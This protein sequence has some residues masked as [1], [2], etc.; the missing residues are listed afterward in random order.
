M[1]WLVAQRVLPVT[2]LPDAA[3]QIKASAL[4]F[5]NWVLAGN[6]VNYLKSDDATSPVQH[7]WSLSVEEQFYLLWPLIFIVAAGVTTLLVRR[8][9]RNRPTHLTIRGIHITGR[10]IALVLAL[11][12]VLISLSYS[13]HETVSNPAGA[14]FQTG[15][16]IWE[17]G[18]GGLLALLP[19][20]VLAR[21]GR[22]GSLSW[23]GLAVIVI[24]AFTFSASTS[25]PGT[26]ALW[27]VLGAAAVLACGSSSARGGSA[28]LMSQRP[29]VALGDLSYGVYLWHFPLIIL[30]QAYHGAGIG[31]LDGP[32]IIAASI[33]LA[34]LTKYLVEDPI[35]KA[36]WLSV[37]TKRSMLVVVLTLIPVTLVTVWQV[38]QPAAKA[39]KIDAAH[40]GAAA[41][42]TSALTSKSASDVVTSKIIP[43]LSKVSTDYELA[44]L[45][46]CKA[47]LTATAAKVCTFG[48][49]TNP[50]L[51]VALVGDSHAAQWSTDLNTIAKQEHWKLV[52]ETH[53]SCP[54]SSTESVL[55][56]QS[57]P[58]TAC[59]DWG[60]NVL[61]NLLTTIHPNVVIVSERPVNGTVSDHKADPS[62]MAAIGAGM[63][64]YWKQLI[65][66]GIKV[67]A[68]HETPEPGQNIP[69]CLAARGATISGC[70][71]A[72]SKAVTKDTPTDAAVKLMGGA[73][74]EV[75]M[76]KYICTAT[77]CPAVVGDV[78][79]Y[80]D[81]QHLSNTYS[82][83]IEPYLKAALLKLPA[84]SGKASTP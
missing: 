26:I 43:A 74:P 17:L 63:A 27:P 1:T 42:A 76:D 71:V 19:G 72:A 64:N 29:L 28:P 84:L 13:A 45:S 61:S 48:D 46:N 41:I 15:T 2:Q 78:I 14:Y 65:A 36:R 37:S 59:Y 82:E 33:V 60:K 10:A 20:R 66:H 56:G 67:V 21:I 83:S 9:L 39:A 6:S 52:V 25:F 3:T 7:F 23:I 73:V 77:T 24:T 49:T 44:S 54:F 31:Y 11:A 68:I 30:W 12:V 40:P 32:A 69:D 62:S 70:A 38:T 57:V 58:F 35:R 4:Y 81:N 47:G 8:A 51:T 80:R 75:N 53:D 50:T 79:V 18:V 55:Q 16:R 5:Q 34:Y 22:F